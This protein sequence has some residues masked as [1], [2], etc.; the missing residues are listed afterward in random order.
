MGAGDAGRDDGDERNGERTTG[1]DP[2]GGGEEAGA[3]RGG[4]AT[5]D[6]GTAVETA[7]AAVA[8]RGG[9]GGGFPTARSGSAEPDAGA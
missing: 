4:R 9:Q 2:A 1:G 3:A 6:R 7:G 5:W 8:V